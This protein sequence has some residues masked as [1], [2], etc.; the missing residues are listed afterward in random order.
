[1]GAGFSLFTYSAFYDSVSDLDILKS[2]KLLRNH[3]RVERNEVAGAVT[4]A[5]AGLQHPNSCS[6]NYEAENRR[7][8]NPQN[9]YLQ[10][11]SMFYCLDRL[12]VYNTGIRQNL[13]NIH[14]G[15]A[16]AAYY[17]QVIYN[18]ASPIRNNNML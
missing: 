18:F 14:P 4:S 2:F 9:T 16:D 10:L 5:G 3:T 15:I 1:M 17:W 12:R 11:F 7:C 8:C 6:G 13:L